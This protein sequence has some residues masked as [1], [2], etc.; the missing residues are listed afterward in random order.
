MTLMFILI[1]FKGLNEAYRALVKLIF[2]LYTDIIANIRRVH[3]DQ[4]ETDGIKMVLNVQC[5][6][7]L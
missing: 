3:T 4:R 5:S 7:Y 6:Y 2:L 1:G